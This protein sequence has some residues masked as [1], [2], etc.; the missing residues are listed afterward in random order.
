M[1]PSQLLLLS[2]IALVALA[3]PSPAYNV[4][5]FGHLLSKRQSTSA[6][7]TV[8][9]EVDLGYEQYQGVA[10]D[11]TGLNTFRG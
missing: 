4:R 6:S 2:L 10:D 3:S 7:S 11:S 1:Y 9:L 8:E 5:P